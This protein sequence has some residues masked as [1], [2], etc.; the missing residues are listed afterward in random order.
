MKINKAKNV[1]FVNWRIRFLNS[2]E[3]KLTKSDINNDKSLEIKVQP[4][5][6]VKR[7]RQ[8]KKI[9]DIKCDQCPAI[10]KKLGSYTLHKKRAH[11]KPHKCKDCSFQ[12]GM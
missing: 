8:V 9:V 4:K 11:I 7:T 2:F 10:F 5:A 12:S 6:K 3:C 1:S